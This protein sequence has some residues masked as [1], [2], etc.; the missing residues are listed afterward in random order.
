MTA[1]RDV[2]RSGELST[3]KGIASTLTGKL[4]QSTIG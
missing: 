4:S 2:I 3:E 1:S